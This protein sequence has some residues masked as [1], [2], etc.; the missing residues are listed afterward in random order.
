M[1]IIFHCAVCVC[2]CV[3]L[4]LR[5]F[6]SKTSEIL[7]MVL[8]FLCHFAHAAERKLK[9]REHISQMASSPSPL[10]PMLMPLPSVFVVIYVPKIIF[11]DNSSVCMRENVHEKKST[12]MK[13]KLPH[14][15]TNICTTN[16]LEHAFSTRIFPRKFCHKYKKFFFSSTM[17]NSSSNNR[18]KNHT[19]THF[20]S[21]HYCMSKYCFF[22]GFQLK[23]LKL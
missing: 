2:V 4:L 16:Q 14:L 12:Q 18:K 3:P 20:E 1:H 23:I 19:Y 8:L 10:P 22:F 13:Q 9:M 21:G 5:V 11:R 15:P 6:V 7:Y 17:N